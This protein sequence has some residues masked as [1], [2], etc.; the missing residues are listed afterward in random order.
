MTRYLVRHV[1]SYTYGAMMTSGQTLAHLRVRATSAQEVWSSFAHCDPAP[2]EAASWVDGFGNLVDM[3]AVR[4]PHGTLQV[5]CES[6]VEVYPSLLVE[7]GP[8]WEEVRDRL[9]RNDLGV[10]AVD[11]DL[12]LVHACR[13]PSRFVSLATLGL[14]ALTADAFTP[15]RPIGE[16]LTDLCHLIFER[17]EFDTEFSDLSTPLAAVLEHRRGVCQ[18]FAHLTIGCL[19]RLGLSARYVS[20]YLETDPP[21]GQPKLIGSDASH[22]WC[23]TYVPDVGWIDLDPTNDLLPVQRHVTVGWGRDYADV[24]PLRGVVLGPAAPQHLEVAVDVTR[25]SAWS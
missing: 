16:A 21:P 20:G 25:V 23:A 13:L 22:A 7:S 10:S 14:D 8:P 12:Y 5:V 19:R 18:D 3:F 15:G 17:F 1:T 9:A 11:E 24:A 2:D 6:E 4:R